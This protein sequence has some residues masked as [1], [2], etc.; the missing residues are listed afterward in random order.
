MS[1][2]GAKLVV[3]GLLSCFVGN[4]SSGLAQQPE[5]PATQVTKTRYA[6]EDLVLGDKV[7]PDTV[8]SRTYHCSR[9][10]QFTGFTWCTNRASKGRVRTAYSMLHSSDDKIVYANK[11]QE[12]AF[13]SSTAAKEELQRISQK[14]GGQPKIIDMPHRSAL[15]DGFIAVWGDV[16]LTPVDTDNITKLA[17][18]KSPKLGF[19]VDFIT[20]FQRS[21]KSGLPIYR[22]GGGAGLVLAVSYGKPEQGTLRLIAVDASEFSAPATQQHPRNTVVSQQQPA[23]DQAPTT[24]Q[25][26][27]A[28]SSTAPNR[29]AVVPEPTPTPDQSPNVV[30]PS[31]QPIANENEQ[32]TKITELRHTIASLRLEL[33]TSAART[34][35]LENQLSESER[36]LKQEAQARLNAEAAKRQTE[37]A[38]LQSH[39]ATQLW[40]I[41]ADVLVGSLIALLAILAPTLWNRLKSSNIA[42]KLPNVDQWLGYFERW[43]S[44]AL[45]RFPIPRGFP[46]ANSGDMSVKRVAEMDVTTQPS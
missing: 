35:K 40:T 7:D 31:S 29:R 17:D 19:L 23:T 18:G 8:T 15:G 38:M 37:Q 21:A 20:D 36:Q 22:I 4:S 41:L 14:I 44:S 32:Q 46:K 30:Q 12:P 11:T 6:V 2:R 10:E 43:L 27:P 25:S 1:L 39:K 28:Q 45:A 34:T 24:A 13:S 16:V 3:C 33:A 9:S 42:S 26:S 5:K